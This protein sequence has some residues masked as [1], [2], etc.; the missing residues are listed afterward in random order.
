MLAAIT[1]SERRLLV[2]LRLDHQQLQACKNRSHDA[3]LHLETDP[4]VG[5]NKRRKLLLTS[6][7]CADIL[8]PSDNGHSSQ[9]GKASWVE[10]LPCRQ[11]L[12]TGR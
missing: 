1:L 8:A 3:D 12:D 5:A 7:G 11:E 4:W 2:A 10:R 6:T 9:N